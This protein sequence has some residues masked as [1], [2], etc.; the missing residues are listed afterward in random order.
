[1]TFKFHALATASLMGRL[2]RHALRP[3]IQHPQRLAYGLLVDGLG[4]GR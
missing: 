1:M 2:L 3:T 4:A